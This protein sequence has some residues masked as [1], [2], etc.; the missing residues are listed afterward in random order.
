MAAVSAHLA[1]HRQGAPVTDD[2]ASPQ[3]AQM[4]DDKEDVL[5]VEVQTD[6]AIPPP[7]IV[8]PI[9]L[10]LGNSPNFVAPPIS[11]KAQEF[12]ID[13]SQ[14]VGED[15]A[16]AAEGISGSTTEHELEHRVPASPVA[17][18]ASLPSVLGSVSSVI[19]QMCDDLVAVDV[20]V[21]SFGGMGTS[22]CDNCTVL[23]GDGIEMQELASDGECGAAVPSL[24]SVLGPT[25]SA[26]GQVSDDLGAVD[27]LVGGV[28]GMG[29]PMPD[30]GYETAGDGFELPERVPEGERVAEVASRCRRARRRRQ[31]HGR[32][33]SANGPSHCEALR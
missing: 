12:Y 20:R 3:P 26:I 19:E 30:G 5:A 2:S 25:P 14:D 23:D 18:V 16:D 24:L 10:E 33:P 17:G 1:A 32:Q 31:R 13:G 22:M 29:I 8:V 28:S 21:R 27:V 7:Y 6:L 11:T 15:L 9:W 4:C